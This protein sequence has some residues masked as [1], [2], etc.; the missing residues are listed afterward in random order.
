[1][2]RLSCTLAVCVCVH[3]LI[4]CTHTKHAHTRTH[5][6][7]H[8]HTHTHTYANAYAYTYAYT[9]TFH[10][11]TYTFHIFMSAPTYMYAQI[12]IQI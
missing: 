12:R 5:A 4:G 10:I 7:T 11:F 8:A 9:Y 2:S 3:E 1:M 6:R